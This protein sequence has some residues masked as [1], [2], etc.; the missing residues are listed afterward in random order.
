[1]GAAGATVTAKA[2]ADGSGDVLCPATNR[3]NPAVTTV[4]GDARRFAPIQLGDHVTVTGNFETVGTTRFLSVWN[5]MLSAGLLTSSAPG[6]PDYVL[7]LANEIDAPAFNIDR[8]RAVF[9][10]FTTDVA[11][12]DVLIW[13]THHDPTTNAVH[14]FPL[15]S[16]NGCIAVGRG[17]CQ[18]R[19]HQYHI[20]YHSDFPKVTAAQFND[21]AQLRAEPRFSPLPCPLGGTMAEQFGVMSPIPHETQYRTG[22]KLADLS[23]PG[24]PTLFSIDVLGNDAKNGQYVFPMGIGLGGIAMPVPLGGALVDQMHVPYSFDGIPWNIDRRLSPGGCIGPCEATPQPLDPFPNP[25]LDPR[26]QSASIPTVPF[27]DPAYTA[28]TLSFASD[29][30][31][32]FVDAGVGSFNG[33]RTVL[34]WP[35]ATPAAVAITPTPPLTAIK[36]VITGLTPVAGRVGSTVLIDGIGLAGA[37]TVTFG[38][39]AA[40]SF[41]NVSPTQVSA[42]VPVGAQSGPIGVTTL[43]GTVPTTAFSADRFTVVPAPSVG[44]FT[45]TSGAVGTSVTIAGTG[46]NSATNVS[47]NGTQAVFSV[48]S[49][50]SVRTAVPAGAT[51]GLITV[52]NPGGIGSR[53]IPFTVAAGAPAVAS[54]TPASGPSGT[55]VTLTGS[56]FTGA[57]NVAVN[58]VTASFTVGSDTSITATVPTA[59][60]TGT[61]RVTTPAGNGTIATPFTVTPAAPLSISSF[62]PASAAVGAPVT[63]TGTGFTGLSSVAFNGITATVVTGLSDTSVTATVPAGA[64]TGPITV[65]TPGATAT[66]AA[67]LTVIPAPVVASFTPASGLA[68]TVVTLTGSALTGATAVTFNGTTA[69]FTVGSDTSIT[70]TV[71]VGAT[72]GSIKVTTPGGTATSTTSYTVA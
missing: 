6:Q 25:G 54:F 17:A 42:V 28:G 30:I 72:T 2:A 19:P 57:T 11:A 62:T 46:F 66:S 22:P 41:R 15:A 27:S 45:P 1:M 52:T 4:V 70:A 48:L 20:D 31:L 26:R 32:S 39:V 18:P 40:T 23:R 38:S 10:G 69:T 56:G 37:R 14:E 34:A 71:P 43:V 58:G 29:R 24:G 21:C 8:I 16:V 61:I 13:T 53:P 12:P 7:P 36:P 65:T 3:P 33:D 68:G 59:A 35:P 67:S 63:L 9:E 64:T 44:G 60:T 51:T 49:D 55:L 5:T 47:F 50:T